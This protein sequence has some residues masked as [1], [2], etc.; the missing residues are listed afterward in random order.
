MHFNWVRTLSLRDLPCLAKHM[1]LTGALYKSIIWTNYLC[2]K[3]FYWDIW[4]LCCTW[5]I[6]LKISRNLLLTL[7]CMCTQQ[8]VPWNSFNQTVYI[9][10]SLY[11]DANVTMSKK[12]LLLLSRQIYLF[13]NK[14]C[15]LNYLFTCRVK[16]A[17]TRPA[18]FKVFWKSFL[19]F[20]RF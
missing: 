2:L 15:T 19:L 14:K 5:G 8:K 3:R 10:F 9:V 4:Y 16:L 17:L 13:T 6:Q 11:K 18:W 20:F 7:H 12:E 1:F